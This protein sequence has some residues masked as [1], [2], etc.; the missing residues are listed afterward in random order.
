MAE[1]TRDAKGRFLPGT[2]GNIRGKTPGARNKRNVVAAEFEKQ[3]SA[4]ARVVMDKALDGDM[5]A[6]SLVLTRIS[7]PLRARPPTVEF[8]LDVDAE[9]SEMSK[10]ILTAVAKGQIDPDTA[11]VVLDMISAHVGFRDLDA[12]LEEFRQLKNTRSRQ[13]IPGGVLHV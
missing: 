3:G 1:I 13:R 12:F 11:R 7:P 5:S 8:E 6:A 9:P 4:V 2:S 10:A